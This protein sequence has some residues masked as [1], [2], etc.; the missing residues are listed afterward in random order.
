MYKINYL[1]SNQ[2]NLKCTCNTQVLTINKRR[3]LNYLFLF[4]HVYQESPII[5]YGGPHEEFENFQGPS[6]FKRIL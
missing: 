4:V 2:L 1:N 6:K 3:F 5:I